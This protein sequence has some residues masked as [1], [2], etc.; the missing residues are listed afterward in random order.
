MTIEQDI[1]MTKIQA[2]SDEGL[3]DYMAGLS[4]PAHTTK[5][6]LKELTLYNRKA[7]KHFVTLGM[8]NEDEG[9]ELRSLYISD[10]SFGDRDVSFIRGRQIKPDHLHV[11]PDRDDFLAVVARE[12]GQ[13]LEGDA[14]VLHSLDL[15]HKVPPYLYQYE[16][17]NLYSWMENNHD[18]R[19][20]KNKLNLFCAVEHGL[21]HRAM[22][23]L[24]S[25]YKNANHWCARERPLT[26]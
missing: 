13:Q 24:Y 21:Q 10:C 17:K 6:Y 22:N 12:K 1:T 14:I 3:I 15:L 2:V 7:K 4:I 20:A 11:F 26:T 9:Y 5:K 8:L 23:R 19:R 16:Y 18:G 25:N